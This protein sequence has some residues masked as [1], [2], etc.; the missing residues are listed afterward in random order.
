MRYITDRI[1]VVSKCESYWSWESKHLP[2]KPCCSNNNR[3]EN[4][5]NQ[6]CVHSESSQIFLRVMSNICNTVYRRGRIAVTVQAM[7][8]ILKA[9]LVFVLTFFWELEANDLAL[10]WLSSSTK[11]G[12]NRFSTWQ[13]HCEKTYIQS[14]LNYT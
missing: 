9:C 8:F 11:T 5:S 3:T 4:N 12:S 14:I 13:W 6:F 1:L 7:V 2:F 10:P